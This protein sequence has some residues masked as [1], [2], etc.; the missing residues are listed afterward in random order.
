MS[1]YTYYTC[2]VWWLVSMFL[3][4]Q[5]SGVS[6][7]SKDDELRSW[8]SDQNWARSSGQGARGHDAEALRQ[9]QSIRNIVLGW[10]CIQWSL[11]KAAT[12][13]FRSSMLSSGKLH[14]S[15]PHGCILYMYLALSRGP[16]QNFWQ[17][18]RF[19]DLVKDWKYHQIRLMHACL[20]C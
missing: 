6:A 20:W 13:H 12:S 9:S 8:C 11:H 1:V 14:A 17:S 2:I 4:S 18:F 7:Y 15:Y 5:I 19:G 16:F 10:T 3:L